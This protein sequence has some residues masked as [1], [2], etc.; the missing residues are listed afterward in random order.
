MFILRLTRSLQINDE[1]P[2][3]FIEINRT[4]LNN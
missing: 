1:V 4:F 2:I 3:K